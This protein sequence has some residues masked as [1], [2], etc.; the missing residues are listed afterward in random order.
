MRRAARH[1]QDDISRFSI[2]LRLLRQP[3]GAGGQA[4]R[5]NIGIALVTNPRVL[6]LDEPTSGLDSYTADEVR[7]GVIMVG[8]SAGQRVQRRLHLQCRGQLCVRLASRS[9]NL[10]AAATGAAHVLHAHRPGLPRASPAGLGPRPELGELYRGTCQSLSAASAG[11][12]LSMHLVA[13]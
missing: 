3:R 5:V 4:K 6:F 9:G 8:C 1:V 2:C 12:A 13:A 11:L 10:A 7:Q